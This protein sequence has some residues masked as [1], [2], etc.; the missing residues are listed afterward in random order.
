MADAAGEDVQL[1]ERLGVLVVDDVAV[2]G[3]FL[4]PTAG[5]SPRAIATHMGSQ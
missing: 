5:L 4:D 2:L 1:V 3:T